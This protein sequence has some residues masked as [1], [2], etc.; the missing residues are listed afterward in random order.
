[1]SDIEP[2]T[3]F[4]TQ[5]GIP[6]A[7]SDIEY[8]QCVRARTGEIINVYNTGEAVVQGK[9]TALAQELQALA[10]SGM[11]PVVADPEQVAGAEGGPVR[12]SSS[13]TGTT[14]P[15]ETV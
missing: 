14:K 1:M 13:S 11:Q 5:R 6:F 12:G 10:A 9:K 8:G 15:Q 7:V 2:F 4:L 3:S